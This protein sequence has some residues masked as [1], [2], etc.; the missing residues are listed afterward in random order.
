MDLSPELRDPQDWNVG[1][2]RSFDYPLDISA[3]AIEPLTGLLAI[4]MYCSSRVLLRSSVSSKGLLAV[5][6]SFLVAQGSSPD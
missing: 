1:T 5:Q 3:L 4:G 6:Y 2:L